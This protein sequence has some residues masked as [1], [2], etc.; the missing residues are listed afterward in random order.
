MVVP[1]VLVMPLILMAPMAVTARIPVVMGAVGLVVRSVPAAP[2][3]APLVTTE[4]MA[5]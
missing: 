2:T 1:A 3:V 5:S 4:L